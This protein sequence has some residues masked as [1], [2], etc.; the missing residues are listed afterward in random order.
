VAETLRRDWLY[1]ASLL[2][3]EEVPLPNKDTTLVYVSSQNE[4]GNSIRQDGGW[5]AR[6]EGPLEV[7]QCPS[8]HERMLREEGAATIVAAVLGA[9]RVVV[10]NS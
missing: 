3:G 2:R 6:H 1:R 5:G 8:R 7:L 9:A 10:C 4:S